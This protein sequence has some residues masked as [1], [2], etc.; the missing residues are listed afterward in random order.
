MDYLTGRHI[1]CEIK[2]REQLQIQR[3]VNEQLRDIR[4]GGKRWRREEHIFHCF[5]RLMRGGER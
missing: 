4:V 2:Q 3:S 5:C 1:E